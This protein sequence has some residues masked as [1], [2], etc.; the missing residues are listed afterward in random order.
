MIRLPSFPFHLLGSYYIMVM[1]VYD[2]ALPFPSFFPSFLALGI[3][4]G[5]L[6]ID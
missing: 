3:L 4:A 1:C 2:L 6:R 5:W